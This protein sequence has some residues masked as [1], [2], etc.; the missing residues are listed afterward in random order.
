MKRIILIFFIGLIVNSYSYSQ[1]GSDT[2]FFDR[3]S[4]G[5][6]PSAF[7]NSFSAA[8]V[9]FNFGLTK[10]LKFITE[11][12]YILNSIHSKAAHG[13]RLKYGIEWMLSPGRNASFIFGLN[14]IY[15]YVS[16]ERS[17]EVFHPE[18]YSETVLFDKTKKMQGFQL[19]L[20]QFFDLTQNF[21]MSYLFGFGFGGISINDSEE[22]I[23][24]I[25]PIF[26]FYNRRG[27]YNYPIISFNLKY[28]YTLAEFKK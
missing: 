8:Q 27:K 26:N 15:R 3:F 28:M 5:I 21:K 17:R 12:G 2:T 24:D 16:E 1:V 11:T 20:G 22:I 19:S 4:V 9:N 7:I 18:N 6:T 10:R 13:Y 14:G 25:F 23:N